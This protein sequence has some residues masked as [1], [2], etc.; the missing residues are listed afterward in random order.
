MGRSITFIYGVAVYVVFLLTFLYSMGFVG[1][2]LVPKSIDSGVQSHAGVAVVINLALLS[3]FALQHSIMARPAFKRVWTK[4][5]PKPAERSTYILMTS[6]ALILLFLFWQPLPAKVW[7]ASNTLAGTVL[8]VLFWA[9]WFVVLVSTFMI[10]HFDLLG[11]KQIY[12]NLRKRQ[13]NQR[14]FVKIG[15]YRLV[16]HPIM[17]GFMIAFWAAPTMTAGHFLFTLVTTG[18]I[19]IAVLYL[20]EKD[21]IA[22]IGDEYL[23]YQRE[24]PAFVPS[25]AR[26]AAK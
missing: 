8:T 19:V 16:R 22:E 24:V 11:L 26:G 2:V 14:N 12:A 23:A 3:I 10:D 18:Y 20:E 13:E 5:I 7:D 17:T 4:I 15:F 21:L 6:V 1:N 9:G 25:F